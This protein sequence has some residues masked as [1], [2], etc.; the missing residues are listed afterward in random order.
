[1]LDAFLAGD[2]HHALSVGHADRSARDRLVFVF[3]GQ[4]SQWRGMGRRLL[5]QEP[6]FRA[7]IVA[8]DVAIRTHARWSLLDELHDES[9]TVRRIDII[10]PSIFAVQVALA[11]LW[12]SWGVEP[13]AVV[14]QSMGEVAAA[15]VAGALS[16]ED[17]AKIICR[18]SRLLRR[19][20]GAGSMAAVELS[21]EETRDA[22]AGYEGRLSV[23]VSSSPAATVV[24]GETAALE[25]LLAT[26]ERRGVFCRRIKVD[27]ASHSPHMEPLREELLRE[28]AEVEPLTPAMPF[29]STVTGGRSRDVRFDAAYWWRNLREPV[30]FWGA[31]ERLL[32]DGYQ[33]FVEVSPHPIVLGSIQQGLYARG[34]T[35]ALLPSLRRE[36]D[37]RAV[38]L[39]SLGSLYASGQRVNW[40]ALF[41]RGGRCVNLPTY[42]WRRERFWAAPAARPTGSVAAGRGARGG[43]GRHPL[44]GLHV[45]P[46]HESINHLWEL[47]LEL[48]DLPFLEDH[49]VQGVAVL[50]ATAYVEMAS[51]AAAEVFAGR[52][53][54][55]AAV[56]LRK[57]LFVPAEGVLLVQLSFTDEADGVAFRV[58]SRPEGALEG[59]GAWTTHA[60]GRIRFTED[61][62][63][64]ATASA[65]EADGLDA[66]RARC[67]EEASA[68][69]FYSLLE[70]AGYG[71]GPSFRS[72]ERV[73]RREGEAVARL[74]VPQQVTADAAAYRLHPAVLDCGLQLLG[75]T[76]PAGDAAARPSAFV[77]TAFEEARLHGLRP[78]CLWARA[79]LRTGEGNAQRLKGDVSIFDEA[80]R[81]V[82]EFV[83]VELQSLE[84]ATPQLQ[85]SSVADW[86]YEPR[87]EE[88]PREA[89]GVAPRA[90]DGAWLIVADAGGIGDALS[91]LLEKRGEHVLLVKAGAEY[92]RNGEG[93]FV[94]R[95]SQ[96][97]DLRR[98]W[99]EARLAAP[100]GCREVVYLWG[101]DGFGS[102]SGSAES[103][104]GAPLDACLSV[105]QFVQLLAG[106]DEDARARLRLVTRGAQAVCG[107]RRIAVAQSPLWGLGRTLAQEQP[108]LFRGL[109]DLDGEVGTDESARQL[110]E[111][112]DAPGDEPQVA[113]R[114]GARY[115]CRLGRLPAQ[116]AARLPARDEARLPARDEGRPSTRGEARRPPHFYA[117]AT[118]LI[119]G[120][121]GA[122]GLE[123]ARWM[124]GRGARR[125]ILMSRAALPPRREWRRVERGTPLARRIEA[126]QEL[127]ALGVA[128]HLAA[129]DV[130]DEAQLTDFLNSFAEE[131]WPRIRGVVH[132]AGALRDA[133]LTQLDAAAF[134]AV[135]RPK[136]VGGWLLHRAFAAVPLD[137]MVFFSS[138][139]SLL[140]SPGQ[141]NYAAANAFMDALA[142]ERRAQGLPALSINWGAWSEVGLAATEERGGRLAR[143]GFGSITPRQGLEALELLMAQDAPQAGVIPVDWALLRRSRPEVAALPLF[144]HVAFA[145]LGATADGA[146]PSPPP[147][148]TRDI[149]V[150]AGEDERQ[151]LLEDYF[152][153]LVSRILGVRRQAL[154]PLRPLNTLG[155]DSLMAIEFKN[156]VER[157][158]GLSLPMVALMQG[159]SIRD[160][161]ALMVEQLAGRDEG[162]PLPGAVA[163]TAG[164]MEEGG[165]SH[166]QAEALLAGIDSL[167]PEQVNSLLASLMD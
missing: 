105:V 30:L 122:L 144:A 2:E 74:D 150:A 146:A 109:I 164:A 19:Q 126:V 166:E 71:Y 42:P 35:A 26:L 31:V 139:A 114:R 49:R 69:E 120:G 58:D 27:I 79:S 62:T 18:R 131:D 125:I 59:T 162:E 15:H 84:G 9:D 154:D 103:P 98:L 110:L 115:V 117:D 121:L 137:F 163:E 82:A 138:A 77:P 43:G 85:T 97:E 151:G 55:L 23:A 44:L 93:G 54:R 141:A 78:K 13:E 80:G 22:L 76:L 135:W 67:R 28:L 73:W 68:D 157:T 129:A 91:S 112:I 48:R 158:L 130:A 119:T 63:T 6:V 24:S 128:V 140:G 12:R 61:V 156:S 99:Q 7:S 102:N 41:P 161:S 37:E 29:Y 8:S 132:A 38:L 53:F 104:G 92:A 113:F 57:A 133:T 124:A 70:A 118:Y 20:S 101:L 152:G 83:G 40:S 108:E 94:A 3:S 87:W 1:A 145:G 86:I 4:G 106:D 51:A 153:Q 32:E 33:T 149:L 46:A 143:S 134:T 36:E 148:L 123:V 107:E 136:V 88:Q 127:E 100:G 34:R 11:A 45:T 81:V 14:G 167:S 60:T 50:P 116:G 5:D 89:A 111:E 66:A 10:Q 96:K 72:I 159:P 21:L 147:G 160:L 95:P 75:A 17:A 52:P 142:C 165:L 155:L 65:P 56:E 16:L 64:E 90:H 39:G 25:E 47:R